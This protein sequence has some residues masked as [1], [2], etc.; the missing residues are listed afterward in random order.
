MAKSGTDTRCEIEQAGKSRNGKPR[1]W[2]TRHGAPATGRYGVRL[3]EC[4]SAYLD[5]SALNCLQLDP[6]KYSGG[7]GIWGAVPPVFDTTGRKSQSGVHVHARPLPGGDKAIDANFDVVSMQAKTDLFHQKA[8]TITHEAAVSHYVS[9]FLGHDI[10]FL[11]CVKCGALH[12]DAGY[13]ATKPHKKHLCHACGNFFSDSEKSISNP[14]AYFRT[15]SPSF[16]S[17]RKLR[18]AVRTLAIAQKDYPGG[19]QIWA[20]NPALIWT[21]E[22]EEEEG[23]HVHAYKSSQGMPDEDDTFS[24]VT[25]DG[26]L[27]DYTQVAQFMAQQALPHL[28]NKVVSIDCLNCGLPHFD[29]GAFGVTPHKEHECEGCGARFHYR[30]RRKLVVSNPI[31]SILA[32]L[33]R[34][35]SVL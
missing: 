9:Y 12:L 22:R 17:A 15:L 19:L 16:A 29:K 32:K 28:A 6:S 33:E 8:I 20:S 30:G 1:W 26:Q 34:A 23:I 24:S 3:D 4:E 31:V 14:I 13:F 7:V 21:A 11:F 25:I 2:C 35:H 5:V 18:R 27:L 10:K